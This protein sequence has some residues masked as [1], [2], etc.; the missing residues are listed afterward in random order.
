MASIW[1]RSPPFKMRTPSSRSLMR[2]ALSVWRSFF[3]SKPSGLPELS[4]ASSVPLA[5]P[6]SCM[7][8]TSEASSSVSEALDAEAAMR[9]TSVMSF[10]SAICCTAPSVLSSCAFCACSCRVVF[11]R[12]SICA[13]FRL[14]LRTAFSRS[15]LLRFQSCFLAVVSLLA[16][17]SAAAS[18]SA[19]SPMLLSVVESSP[20]SERGASCNRTLWRGNPS[21]STR[22]LNSPKK[23]RSISCGKSA[24]SRVFSHVSSKPCPSA[25]PMVK[26]RS[27]TRH[28]T[29]KISFDH[30][31]RTD[32][33]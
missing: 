14:R 33:P 30:R 3:T 20:C 19:S 5:A 29:R 27:A 25:S 7:I 31:R 12:R 9:A 10:S 1:S 13:R 8:A 15:R 18:P 11:S 4:V 26:S 6:A 17:L 22:L 24:S 32:F 16:S 23:S 21:G 28:S 2:C